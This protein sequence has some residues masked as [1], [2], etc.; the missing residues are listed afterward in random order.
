MEINLS[1]MIFTA[2][3][4]PC[5]SKNYILY[6]RVE[7]GIDIDNALEEDDIDYIKLS[8]TNYNSPNNIRRL[9]IANTGVEVHY[10]VT[11]KNNMGIG[12][13]L[14]RE[15]DL[16]ASLETLCN[17][18]D[19]K[20]VGGVFDVL[21]MDYSCRNIEEIY[22]DWILLLSNGADEH[23]G[24]FADMQDL[25]MNT[26]KYALDTDAGKNNLLT[27]L[28]SYFDN[29]LSRLQE[30]FPRLKQIIFV[31]NLS[32]L[33][34]ESNINRDTSLNIK[35]AQTWYDNNKV[36]LEESKSLIIPVSISSDRKPN[37]KFI[38]EDNLYKLDKYD[39]KRITDSFRKKLETER[40]KE[41]Y[42]KLG[43]ENLEVSALSDIES[44]FVD[45]EKRMGTDTLKI[46]MRASTSGLTRVDLLSLF[47]EFSP[48]NR[49]RMAKLL[50]LNIPGV[51]DVDKPADSKEDDIK[52]KADAVINESKN[53]IN[54][55]DKDVD[56]ASIID[57]ISSNTSNGIESIT[58]TSF[59]E[60][61]DAEEAYKIS[62]DTAYLD[63]IN[64]K[65]YYKVINLES[66]GEYRLSK[67]SVNKISDI[68]VLN[69][70]RAYVNPHK[71]L[72]I[73]NDGV[74]KDKFKSLKNVF[75][76]SENFMNDTS[77][78]TLYTLVSEIPAECGLNEN[79]QLVVINKGYL[80]LKE[81]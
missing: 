8:K 30:K 77:E 81:R 22:V 10:Y 59:I 62:T 36:L 16:D 55:Q 60:Q 31:S 47:T 49:G 74:A 38:I 40:L 28:L 78:V 32:T 23:F 44:M 27:F 71:F 56:V 24:T 1:Q 13:W 57:A 72:S 53:I 80:E 75:N 15:Y 25:V 29:N 68:V 64:D 9:F 20:F 26:S 66:V 67:M 7:I 18:S 69:A 48:E 21:N 14:F 54:N 35:Q 43:S 5:T 6:P 42:G 50:G 45:I 73:A 17:D 12:N 19:T 33:L 65:V 63:T 34:K 58:D 79:N 76:F 4:Q 51:T 46:A 41:K 3:H 2:M 39:L 52:S 11:P 37:G 61:K 70:S